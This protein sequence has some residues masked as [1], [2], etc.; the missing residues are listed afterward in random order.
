M[1]ERGSLR[2]EK[3]VMFYLPYYTKKKQDYTNL[4]STT[5]F[6]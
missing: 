6:Y 5:I 1:D 4:T 3:R 2:E